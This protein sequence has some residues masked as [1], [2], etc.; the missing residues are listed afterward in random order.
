MSNDV[1]ISYRRDSGSTVARLIYHALKHEG[2]ACF[3]DSESIG[4]GD[5]SEHIKSN[6]ESCNNFIFIVSSRVFERCN[7]PDDWVRKEI[8]IALK[9][10][11]KI[12]PIF[13]NGINSFPSGLPESIA[14]MQHANAIEL[15]HKD[16]EGNLK[17][18]ISW[19]DIEKKDKVVNFFLD[20]HDSEDVEDIKLM[21]E[22]LGK[23]VPPDHF[24]SLARQNI[25]KYWNGE[26]NVLLGRYNDTFM[27]ELCKNLELNSSGG[28]VLLLERIENWVA[29]RESEVS[30]DE[31]IS[32]DIEC[33]L[34]EN[35]SKESLINICIDE[36][37][38]VDKRSAEKMRQ[39][40][41]KFYLTEELVIALICKLSVI[42]LKKITTEILGESA[43]QN[44]KAALVDLLCA[45]YREGRKNISINEEL[46]HEQ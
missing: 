46:S 17:R 23:V 26:L 11:K 4:A 31:Q 36:N 25:K 1:F 3:F 32:L 29:G 9:L 39:E 16:F 34:V 2:I 43:A 7:N 15:N 27:K 20:M 19:I 40:L 22:T 35:A 18:L 28:E 12:I 21:L 37:Y 42:D 6:L 30:I 5:F 33:W 41:H 45:S 13:V 10:K 24:M 38:D 8:E 44:K 14:D